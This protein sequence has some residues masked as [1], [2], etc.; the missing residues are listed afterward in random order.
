MLELPCLH[1]IYVGF[2]AFAGDGQDDRKESTSPP[3]D[4][5]NTA[6]FEGKYSICFTL[7]LLY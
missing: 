1:D 3:Y 2:R 7:I 5:K 4:F 6:C